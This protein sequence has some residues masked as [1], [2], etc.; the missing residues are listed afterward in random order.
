MVQAWYQGGISV[1]DFT[2]PE[3]PFEIAYFDRG[4]MNSRELVLGGHW[5]AYWYNGAIYASEIGRGLDVLRLTPSEH[6]SQNEIDAATQVRMDSFNPQLQTRFRFPASAATA[7]AYLDQ[8]ARREGMASARIAATARELDRIEALPEGGAK[9]AAFAT[10]ASRLEAE[11]R[12]AA[13]GARVRALAATVRA[14]AGMAG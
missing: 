3:E 11:A 9:R 12:V 5:S 14:L 8:L 2:D 7:R 4:P 10:M 1:F 6:L 13:D